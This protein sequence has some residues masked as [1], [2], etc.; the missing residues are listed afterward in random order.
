MRKP[1]ALTALAV[2]NACAPFATF[3]LHRELLAEVASICSAAS[4]PLTLAAS[5]AW[6]ESKR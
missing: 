6:Q 2:L 5:I 3:I 4:V 1:I